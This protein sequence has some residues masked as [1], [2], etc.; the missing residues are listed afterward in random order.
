MTPLTE[1]TLIDTGSWS[2][3]ISWE[4]HASSELPPVELCTAVFCLAEVDDNRI[5][6]MRA[7]RGWGLLGGHIEDGET[8]LDA[9]IR[10]TR[11]EGG[12]IP[13]EPVPVAYRKI[14]AQTPVTHQDASKTYPFPTSYIVYYRAKTNLSLLQ[15]TGEE[16]IE[17]GVFTI[18][19]ALEICEASTRPLLRLVTTHAPIED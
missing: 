14:T 9:L 11:E 19:E 13:H 7:K 1:K 12:F 6:L 3:S 16:V 5:V 17:S 18:G 8:L 4:L 10:E 15:P 2:D